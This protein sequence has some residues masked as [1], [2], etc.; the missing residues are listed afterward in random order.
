METPVQNST[1]STEASPNID[2][3]QPKKQT[4]APPALPII[5]IENPVIATPIP[6][7]TPVPSVQSIPATLPLPER[8]KPQSFINLDALT[9][10]EQKQTTM[11]SFPPTIGTSS[12]LSNDDRYVSSFM[13]GKDGNIFENINKTFLS[14]VLTRKPRS[15]AMNPDPSKELLVT[16]TLDGSIQFVDTTPKSRDL[17]R[18]ISPH[19]TQNGWSEE[20]V[21]YYMHIYDSAG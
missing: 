20:I 9:T 8:S 17:I 15:I 4:P 21:L 19:I 13:R 18:I 1:S 16:T 5:P 7:P 2:F 3:M 6:R 14:N 11:Q 12:F 10:P